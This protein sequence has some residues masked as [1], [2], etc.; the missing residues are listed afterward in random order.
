MDQSSTIR[1]VEHP[2]SK[3]VNKG[4]R[5]NNIA[6]EPRLTMIDKDCTSLQKAKDNPCAWRERLSLKTAFLSSL[7]VFW[8]VA[9]IPPRTS[10]AKGTNLIPIF[11]QLL[12][13]RQ[14]FCS[15]KASSAY[16]AFVAALVRVLDCSNEVTATS[17]AASFPAFQVR[18]N[19]SGS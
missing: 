13:L 1:S 9:N 12:S 18:T 8:K 6:A 7:S 5:A 4:A 3:I 17:N 16:R 11:E 10:I 14:N 19:D 15:S 2:K